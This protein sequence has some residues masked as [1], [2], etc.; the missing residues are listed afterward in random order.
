MEIQR[1][2]QIVQKDV[3]THKNWKQKSRLEKKSTDYRNIN[4]KSIAMTINLP[5]LLEMAT[6]TSNMI[7]GGRRAINCEAS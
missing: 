6:T 4:V 2:L 1:Q 5:S 3:W 7:H